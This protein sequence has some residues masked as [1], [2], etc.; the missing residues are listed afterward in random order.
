[1]KNCLSSRLNN[2]LSALCLL[3]SFFAQAQLS[4]E[5][6]ILSNPLD[7]SY[8]FPINPGRQNSLTGTMGELRNTHFHA[9]ID[10][11][12]NNAIGVPV[13]ATQRGYVSYVSISAYGYGNALFIT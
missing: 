2:F 10:I 1:M 6:K 13:R 5:K 12:T 9:G 11:R 7:E 4:P 3:T 8:L